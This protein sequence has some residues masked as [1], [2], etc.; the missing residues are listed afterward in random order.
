LEESHHQY[1]SLL[2][3]A[4]FLIR[5]IIFGIFIVGIFKCMAE[6]V[7]KRRHFIKKFGY[8]GGAY[9]LAWPIA[10][11]FSELFLPNYMHNEVVTLVEEGTH[12][13]ISAY[14]CHLFAYPDT[15]FKKVRIKV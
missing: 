9:F 3:L 10:V 15:D 14:M 6:S 1:E 8:Q 2:G 12:I 13:V 4:L 11:I 5:F 7:G